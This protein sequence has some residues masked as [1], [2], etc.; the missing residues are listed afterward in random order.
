V[1]VVCDGKGKP[2]LLLHNQAQAL[3]RELGLTS[4]AASLS[5]TATHAIGFVVASSGSSPGEDR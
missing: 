1:E 2:G 3:A 4:W 5:H